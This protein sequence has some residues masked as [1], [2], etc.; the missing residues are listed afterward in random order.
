FDRV[1]NRVNPSDPWSG[2]RE[3]ELQLHKLAARVHH[4]QL[5]RTQRSQLRF[6]RAKDPQY[7]R[8]GSASAHFGGLVGGEE[9]PP[10]ACLRQ[11]TPESRPDLDLRTVELDQQLLPD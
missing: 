5:I 1:A 7:V 9:E 3:A 8:V 4:G 2:R 10:L 11:A 6:L